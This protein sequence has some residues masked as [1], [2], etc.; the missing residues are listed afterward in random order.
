MTDNLER[1]TGLAIAVLEAHVA[2]T[3]RQRKL[4]AGDEETLEAITRVIERLRRTP[5]GVEVEVVEAAERILR[6]C[7]GPGDRFIEDDAELIARAL[8]SSAPAPR[9]E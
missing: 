2:I 3:R 5:A 9:K 1:E 6:G 7:Y 4:Y 8:T